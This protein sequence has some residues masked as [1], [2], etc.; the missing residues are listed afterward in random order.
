MAKIKSKKS[1]VDP[2]LVKGL[3]CVERIANEY[4]WSEDKKTQ[5]LIN[6]GLSYLMTK[7]K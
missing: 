2:E 4:G 1:K 6:Y 5:A 3:K 7:E